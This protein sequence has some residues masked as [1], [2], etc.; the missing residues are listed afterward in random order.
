M[1]AEFTSYLLSSGIRHEPGPPHS[2]QLNGV[3]ERE[4]RTLSD[5]IRCLLVEAKVPKSFWADALRHLTFSINSIPC[6][7]P[8]G[9]N[10]PN[11]IT[12]VSN[13]N[14]SSLHPFGCLVWYKVPEANRRKLDPKGRSAILLSYLSNGGG[15]RLWDLGR[16]V[17]IKSRDVIFNDDVF[18]YGHS[19]DQAPSTPV[20]IEVVWA[21]STHPPPASV[22]PPCPVPSRADTDNGWSVFRSDRRL[23]ASI[24][25][26][27]AP[28]P[29]APPPPTPPPLSP[30]L[31][32]SPPP[33][34][35][36]LSPSPP[37]P[38]DLHPLPLFPAAQAECVV[39]LFALELKPTLLHPLS[40]STF[41]RHGNRS[42]THQI[43]TSGSRPLMKNSP[44]CSV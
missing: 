21:Q 40:Q 6:N 43:V 30:P 39:R 32:P 41:P 12:E 33:P 2:P 35:T 28:P 15:Y 13:V 29:L 10:S 11:T 24:H 36:P 8:A 1:S 38:H 27:D 25:A 42:F 20:Q 37:L 14:P 44:P 34:P 7:T 31:P 9:Y 17:F 5:K 26:P 22:P 3:A 18:P 16:R 19:T 23:R 4:N